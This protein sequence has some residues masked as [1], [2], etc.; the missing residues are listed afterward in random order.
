MK[1]WN[2]PERRKGEDM[3]QEERDLLIRMDEKLSNLVKSSDLLAFNFDKH[4]A[5]DKK[6]FGVLYKFMWGLC[7]AFTLFIVVLKTI[8]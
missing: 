6:Q 5:D 3:S 7:G 2:E 1:P 4:A 8:K